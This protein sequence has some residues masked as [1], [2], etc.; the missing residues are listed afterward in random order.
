MVVFYAQL[1]TG[2]KMT[3]E[4][5]SNILNFMTTVDCSDEVR[6]GML[7]MAATTLTADRLKNLVS[8]NVN[9]T[10]EANNQNAEIFKFTK[11][12]ILKMPK[13]FRKEFRTAGCTAH[14]LKRR[15][16]KNNWN[17]LIRYRRNGY[18]EIG[19]AHV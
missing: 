15:S 3:E 9:T 1:K 18:Y 5:F 7:E 10:A 14:V 6:K 12:E 11:Q 4:Q 17:Y 16:G 19:R 8:D 13:Q 2:R